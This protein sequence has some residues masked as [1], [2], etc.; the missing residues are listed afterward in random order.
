MDYSAGKIY[1]IIHKDTGKF[2]IG[3]TIRTLEK[4]FQAHKQDAKLS[5][6]HCHIYFNSIHWQNT[7][8]ELLEN[9]NCTSRNELLAKETEYIYK[10]TNNP[11]CLN[12][13]LPLLTKQIAHERMI[14]NF[15]DRGEKQRIKSQQV[16]VAILKRYDDM[17]SAK[18]WIS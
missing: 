11:L 6:Q 5:K 14:K 18:S 2:Y 4:R 1:R 17:N 12:K 15:R 10:E 8:I 7:E 16:T 9:C 3:S 13:L